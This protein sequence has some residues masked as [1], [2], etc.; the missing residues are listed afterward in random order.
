MQGIAKKH[1][2]ITRMDKETAIDIVRLYKQLLQEYFD[3][4]KVYLFGSY[5]TETNR[6]DSDIEV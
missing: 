4:E 6:E 2:R 5:A 1:E 3:L